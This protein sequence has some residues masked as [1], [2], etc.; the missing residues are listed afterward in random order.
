MR[1][2]LRFNLRTFLIAITAFGIWLGLHVHRSRLQE[3]AVRQI[4]THGGWVA[5]DYQLPNGENFDP[6]SVSPVPAWLRQW[7]G[8]DFF[9][10]VAEI[11][12]HIQRTEDGALV[13]VK[14]R[15]V[16]PLQSLLAGV[17]NTKCLRLWGPQV[18]NTNLKA[19]AGLS[20]LESLV[21]V[22]GVNVS[23]TG[24][25][26]LEKLDQLHWLVLTGSQITDESMSVFAK[27]PRLRVLNLEASGLTNSGAACLSSSEKLE[28]LFLHGT[29]NGANEVDDNGIMV[30]KSL[31]NLEFL[32]V[33]DTQVT[34]DG[35]AKFTASCPSCKVQ[36]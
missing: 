8:Y 3:Q 21:I 35:V 36:R 1:K 24:V 12:F 2:L 19:V 15:E 14:N 5:Y 6:N 31:P 32:G 25:A 16:L 22:D 20:N 4:R 13:V 23:D 9:H 17:P 7:L 11:S 28:K 29:D 33:K 30:L 10:S 34:D 26:H 18:N 27:L